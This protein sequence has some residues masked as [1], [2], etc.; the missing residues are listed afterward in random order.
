MAAAE[1]PHAAGADGSHRHAG[2]RGWVDAWMPSL[3]EL[4]LKNMGYTPSWHRLPVDEARPLHHCR[5]C[6]HTQTML[7]PPSHPPQVCGEDLGMIP[8]CVHPV[9]AELGLIGGWGCQPPAIQLCPHLVRQLRPL[10]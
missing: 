2:V 7:I 5:T 3:R 6:T 8:A 4:L 1:P 9:M 10:S